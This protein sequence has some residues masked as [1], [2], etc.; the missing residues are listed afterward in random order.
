MRASLTTAIAGESSR[1]V[2]L[3]QTVPAGGAK[4]VMVNARGFELEDGRP[5]VLMAMEVLGAEE[6]R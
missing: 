2:L 5:W 4:R 3:D 1:C 6:A